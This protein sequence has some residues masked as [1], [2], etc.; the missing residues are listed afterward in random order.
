MPSKDLRSLGASYLFSF[1]ISGFVA[2]AVCAIAPT[3]AVRVASI[4]RALPKGA[5]ASSN[6]QLGAVGTVNF[7]Y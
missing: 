1:A 6:Q 3:K 7:S 5:T 4:V 2:L